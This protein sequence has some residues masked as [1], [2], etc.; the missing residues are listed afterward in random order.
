MELVTDFLLLAATATACLYCFV[1]SRRLKA[2]TSAEGGLGAG[3]A[4][5]TKSAEEMKAAVERSKTAADETAARLATLIETADTKAGDLQSLIDR[6]DEMSAG[7]VEQ[8]EA[9]TKTYVDTIAP[10]IAQAN[11]A[12]Q[13]LLR[14]METAPEPAADAEADDDG[15]E[16]EYIDA[17]GPAKTGAAA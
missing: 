17:D 5:L 12:S 4:A 1:L 16:F 10:F 9:A 15:A 13:S 8:A 2:L 3:I 7:I 11:A 14:A 6:L